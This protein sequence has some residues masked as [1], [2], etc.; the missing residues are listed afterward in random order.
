[1][2]R[3][4]DIVQPRTRGKA[5]SAAIIVYYDGN[6]P[7]CRREVAYYQRRAP[8]AAIVWR[9]LTGGESVLA[10]EPFSLDEA[11]LLLHV[12]DT[13]GQLHIGLEAHLVMWS[14]LPGLRWLAIM[15]SHCPKFIHTQL[16]RFYRWL[17]WWR[18]GYR[19]HTKRCSAGACDA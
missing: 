15:L 4:L 3:R 8:E 18:P 7:Y 17:A 13:A 16:D 9:N 5:M 12:R 19:N 1:M 11:L 2:W 6:C 14:A 10:E